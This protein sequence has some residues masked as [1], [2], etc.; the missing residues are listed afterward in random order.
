MASNCSRSIF[1]PFFS[2]NN[3]SRT[4]PYCIVCNVSWFFS[5][6]FLFGHFAREKWSKNGNICGVCTVF[7][8]CTACDVWQNAQCVMQFYRLK[9]RGSEKLNDK[10]NSKNLTMAHRSF[11]FELIPPGAENNFHSRWCP[12]NW[13]CIPFQF[14]PIDL[15]SNT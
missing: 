8:V 14:N 5:S 1:V 6:T 10:W 12:K 2:Q 11:I 3:F 4:P 15:F 9:L 13:N 7:A